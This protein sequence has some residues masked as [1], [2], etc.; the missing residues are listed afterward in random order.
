MLTI[1][2]DCPQLRKTIISNINICQMKEY[3]YCIGITPPY[4][5]TQ[6]VSSY[7]FMPV[8]AIAQ[9]HQYNGDRRINRQHNGGGSHYVIFDGIQ[10]IHIHPINKC[11]V[12]FDLSALLCWGEKASNRLFHRTDFRISA[13]FFQHRFL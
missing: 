11:H 3:I 9:E 7:L 2:T 4:L 6:Q 12:I 10:M 1:A 13:F 5:V 8:S